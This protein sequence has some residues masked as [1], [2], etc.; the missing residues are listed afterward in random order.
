MRDVVAVLSWTSRAT[1]ERRSSV[2]PAAASALRIPMLRSRLCMS[3]SRASSPRWP[4][5][6]D[7]LRV[8]RA[9]WYLPLQIRVNRLDGLPEEE[10]IRLPSDETHVG[11]QDYVLARTKRMP[12]WERLD[13]VDVQGRPGDAI[14]PQRGEQRLLV[15][16]RAPC[17]VDEVGT[18]L[19][20]RE[21]IRP[22]DAAGPLGE[23]QVDP[24]HVALAEQLVQR[25]AAG[26]RRPGAVFVGRRFPG[27]QAHREKFPE[28]RHTAADPA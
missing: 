7:H 10:V 5:V 23:A 28:R 15:H 6:R 16:Q 4:P 12:G 11:R 3:F 20:R 24:H 17:A 25:D 1:S 8:E 27:E 13:L 21:L 19:H 9:R 18:A 14:L 26:A 2:L 22:D